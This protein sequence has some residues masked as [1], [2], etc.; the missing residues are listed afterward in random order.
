[1]GLKISNSLEIFGFVGLYLLFGFR[2]F[3][4]FEENSMDKYQ[5]IKLQIIIWWFNIPIYKG[6]PLV[7]TFASDLF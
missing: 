5:N 1:M 4:I 7:V 2:F 6:F 3:I